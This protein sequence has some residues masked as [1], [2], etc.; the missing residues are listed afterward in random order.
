MRT[1]RDRI[2]D[3]EY[4]DADLPE[5]PG[6]VRRKFPELGPADQARFLALIEQR[7]S[8]ATRHGDDDDP[9]SV[10]R[11]QL[12]VL[13]E[14]ADA[15]PGDVRAR[16]PELVT[17]RPAPAV[18][19]DD[20]ESLTGWVGDRPELDADA[21]VRLPIDQVVGH[22]RTWRPQQKHA[23]DAPNIRGQGDALAAAVTREPERFAAAA[24][25]F[26]GLERTYVR[27]FFDGV[28]E[29]VKAHRKF[30][31]EPVLMLAAWAIT[32]KDDG[33]R[34][35]FESDPSW[36]WT[37]KS[38]VD[39]LDDALE[40]G[41]DLPLDHRWSVWA[42]LRE[43]ASD[44]EPGALMPEDE[45]EDA[46][47]ASLNRVVGQAMHATVK[48]VAWVRRGV[49]A[50]H[51]RAMAL[52]PEAAEVLAE[53]IDVERDPSVATRGALGF[54][55]AQLLSLDA[56]WMTAQ[57][58]HLFPADKP[59]ADALAWQA[60]VCWNRPW[61][62]V[63][64]QFPQLYERATQRVDAN[65][66]DQR[67]RTDPDEHLVEHLVLFY[68][69]GALTI[70]SAIFGGFYQRA[71]ARLRAHAVEE[72]GR[73]LKASEP[74]LPEHCERAA[75]F[76][77]ARRQALRA[78]PPA[79]RRVELEQF[80]WWFVAGKCDA[81]W[82]RLELIATTDEVGSIEPDSLVLDQLVAI[83]PAHPIDATRAVENLIRA[84][85][86]RWFVDGHMNQILSILRAASDS[87]EAR[88]PARAVARKLLTAGY[89][90]FEDLAK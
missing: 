66:S 22:L 37:R 4:T 57:V 49:D 48:Y 39:L 6:L 18:A 74:L 84:P 51:E 56:S 87:D 81:T 55:F 30:A 32:Q 50:E 23:L 43:L 46:L 38:I 69:R 72:I 77:R 47:T 88:A 82:L 54:R 36:A 28:R 21:L 40:A 41:A 83:A 75:E 1:T 89:R 70:D 78:Q 16:F 29:A 67:R 25:A 8:M 58:G 27:S 68:L 53:H 71:P 85:K 14:I 86:E 62:R 3:P 33:E 19:D 10:R 17:M 12:R 80:G 45:R 7:S 76:W 11:W 13:R 5:F 15:L 59:V 35:G 20:F 24:A 79:E 52:A 90:A 42:V 63:L 31:W 26:E 34:S 64:D 2:L 65:P 9:A 44:R 60:Y 61:E 73:L